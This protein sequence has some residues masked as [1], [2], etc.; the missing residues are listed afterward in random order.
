MK[1]A[2]VVAKPELFKGTTV[3]VQGEV[4]KA[5]SKMGCWMEIADTAT[6]DAPGA[7]VTFKDYGFFIPVDSAGAHAR[8]QGVL[9][10]RTLTPDDVKHMEGEGAKITS[11]AADGSAQ[12]LSIV[13]TGVELTKG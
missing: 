10:I 6:P 5:C 12:E 1:I 3:V 13:A 7:R 11:K 2:D 4:R 8:V 9:D